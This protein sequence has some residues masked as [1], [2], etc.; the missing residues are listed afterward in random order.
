[1]D[2]I[3]M[4][5]HA[6]LAPSAAHRWLHCPGSIKASEGIEPEPSVYA[7]EGT[8]AHELAAYCLHN[9]ASA[10]DYLHCWPSV[11]EDMVEPVQFYIDTLCEIVCNGAVWIEQLV[12][13]SFIPGM[14]GGTVDAAFYDPVL[15]ELHIVDLK[16]GKGVLVEVQDNPQLLIYALGMSKLVAAP[17]DTVRTTIV[18]P[19]ALHPDG[20]VRTAVYTRG[21]LTEFTL[22]VAHAAKATLAPDAPL[23]A[24]AWCK[25]CPAAFKCPELLDRTRLLAFE[26][27]GGVEPPIEVEGMAPERRANLLT[28]LNILKVW[29]KRF[30]EHEN[31]LAHEGNPAPGFKLVARRATRRWTDEA[32]ATVAILGA[33]MGII[34][35]DLYE[36]KFISPA[37]A[38]KLLGGKNKGVIE[39]FVSR[40]SSGTILVPLSDYRPAVVLSAS[41]IFQIENGEE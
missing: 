4:N 3:H 15:R 13:L 38:D 7:D 12:D 41:E 33:D 8:T 24:G 2:D 11:T 35:S 39:P 17:I 23:H 29:I 36:T 19:R 5:A 30:E 26:V 34:M 27:F 28:K 22:T 21:E 6:R 18:Q 9:H 14:E 25:F 31:K 20:P 16:Y 1:M 40:E 37:T 10:R 32:E